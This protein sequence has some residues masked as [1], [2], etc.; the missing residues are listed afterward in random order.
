MAN[1]D[2]VCLC[3][4]VHCS[5]RIFEA[6]ATRVLWYFKSQ[7]HSD[8]VNTLSVCAACVKRTLKEAKQNQQT[9]NMANVFLR[10]KIIYFLLNAMSI[11]DT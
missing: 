1:V 4:I 10:G 8:S 2:Y 3:A 11:N 7:S 5:K 6:I 9:A